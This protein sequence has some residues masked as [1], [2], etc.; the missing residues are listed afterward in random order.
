[1]GHL[2]QVGHHRLAA[3]GLAQ[4][5]GQRRAGLFIIAAGEHLAQID[6]FADLVGQ[7]DADHIAARNHGDAR[8]HRATWSAPRRRTAKSPGEDLTPAAGSNSYSVTTG[9]GR[10]AVMRPLT[11]KSASTASSMRAF[12][13]SASSVRRWVSLTGDRLGQQVQRRQLIFARRQIERGLLGALAGRLG[14]RLASSRLTRLS[15]RSA[16]RVGG[17]GFRASRPDDSRRRRHRRI[18]SWSS[19]S[20]SYAAARRPFC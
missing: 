18:S 15:R 8:R 7:F 9:P 2:G 5:Q 19:S 6:G 4:R 12:S 14:A 16:R 11:P 1:M 17:D 20:S 13:S 10:T 3:D